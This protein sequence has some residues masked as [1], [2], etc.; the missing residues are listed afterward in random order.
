[1]TTNVLNKLTY[2]LFILSSKKKDKASGCIIDACMQVGI[3]PNR[4][5]ISVMN[6]NCTRK[7]IEKSG[8]FNIAILDEDCPFELIKH[9]GFQSS[10]DVDKFEGLTTFDDLNGVPVVLSYTCASISAKVIDSIDIDSHTIFIADVKDMKLLSN[11]KPMTYSH[12]QE[13][14][15]P[16]T[17]EEIDE[18]KRAPH[19][20]LDKEA[21]IKPD[22]SCMGEKG[23]KKIVAWRCT[24]CGYI[25]SD[26]E[27]PNDYCCDVCGHPM[28]DF[29]PVYD[30]D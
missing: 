12:Y 14:V 24:I 3:L 16:K 15:K 18:E 5:M 1:M 13:H 6:S 30:R 8:V 28:S 23:E 19:H 11:K 27:L 21:D 7:V 25:F 17:E 2:G 26:S 4:I 29:V 22:L 10:R 20:E 9:F